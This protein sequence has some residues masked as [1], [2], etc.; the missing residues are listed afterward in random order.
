MSRSAAPL[1]ALVTVIVPGRDVAEFAAEALDSLRAQTL[2]AWCAILVDDGSVDATADVFADAAASDPRFTLIRHA[3][4]RGLGGAR[5]AGL[6][7]VATPF[8]GFLD[9]DDVMTPTALERLVAAITESGSDLAVGAYVRLRAGAGGVYAAGE[10]QPWV[11]AATDPARRGTT[12]SAHPEVSGNVVAWSKLSR[13]EL[14]R[15]HGV[16]FPEG[17][18]YEDQIVAQRL[19]TH[20]RAIDVLPDVVVHWRERADGSS[21]TQRKDTLPVLTDYLEALRG[22]I[23]VLD[24]ADQ[25]AAA[26]A[27]LRLILE[28]DTPPLV[29]I[30]AGETGHADAA[31]RRAVGAFVRDLVA[32]ADHEGVALDPQTADLRSAAVLW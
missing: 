27:R 29:R 22:G 24:A 26:R 18:L 32:R 2:P 6:D 15:A 16:R 25:H 11:R 9:A 14:W 3:E 30:A 20:A 1:P 5:N 28:M 19:Y 23:A 8:V 12:L 31:Y 4:P 13:V 17:R 10:V 21:I 7:R